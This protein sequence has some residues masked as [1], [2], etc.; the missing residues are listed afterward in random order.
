MWTLRV[1]QPYLPLSRL[2]GQASFEPFTAGCAQLF[3]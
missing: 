3:A 2:Y 1:A